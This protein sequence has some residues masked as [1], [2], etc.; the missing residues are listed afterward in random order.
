VILRP[1][2][3]KDLGQFLEIYRRRLT[4]GMHV[5]AEPCQRQTGQFVIEELNTL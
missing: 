1:L 3:A 2:D 5:V 4:N